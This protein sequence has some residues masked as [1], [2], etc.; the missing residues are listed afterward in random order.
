MAELVKVTALVPEGLRRKA[1]IKAL[2]EGISLS[3]V[4]RNFLEEWAEQDDKAP[5][6]ETETA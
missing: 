3:S 6:D 5:D 2:S 4:L 1:R